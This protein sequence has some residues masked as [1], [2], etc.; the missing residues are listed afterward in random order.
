MNVAVYW[1]FENIHASLGTVKFGQ[2]WYRE[3][4]YARQPALVDI[5]SLMEYI[6]GLGDVNIN[7]AYANWSFF[8]PYS[9]DLQSHA[10]DLI[11]MFPK[12][13]HGK[14]G[15]DIRMAI[16]VIEDITL[17]PHISTI[18][19]VGGDSDYISIAQKVRQRGKK[20]IGI[21]IKETTN[22]Y[23]IKSC[24]EFKFY[25]S[26]LVRSSTINDLESEGYETFDIEEAGE[27]LTK[28]ILQLTASSGERA[29]N[30]AAVKPMMMRLD[31]SFDESNY[32][33]QTFSDF[34][35]HFSEIISIVKGEFDHLVYL[36]EESSASNVIP[37]KKLLCPYERVLKKQ[38]IRLLEPRIMN[39][40]IQETWNLFAE[41]GGVDSYETFKKEVKGRL[42][43]RGV[44]VSD[45]DVAKLKGIL[46]KAFAFNLDYENHTISLSSG[47]SSVSDLLMQVHSMLVKRVVDNIEEKPD[48]NQLAGIL[49]GDDAMRE[50]VEQLVT[51]LS[52]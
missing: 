8:F 32:G 52:R 6:S 31:P 37:T 36:N 11:Q 3:N 10:I 29:A 1:D 5:N 33:F 14:N 28:A 4:R 9:V 45:T 25:S 18:V 16:E 48:T 40:G 51:G 49:Y 50:K 23:W 34:L 20:I 26:L 21:G 35:D 7:K 15:A 17:N 30:K 19:I 12:G 44:I 43:G 27:L 47:V 41:R 22:Q 38:Q 46:Y 24:N 2:N 42:E 13:G 39:I